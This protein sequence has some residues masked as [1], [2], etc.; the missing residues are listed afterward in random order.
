[1]TPRKPRESRK[2][3]DQSFMEFVHGGDPDPAALAPEEAIPLAHLEQEVIG[4]QQRFALLEQAAAAASPPRLAQLA[5]EINQLAQRLLQ[6]EQLE[7]RLEELGDRLVA[8]EETW[9]AGTHFKQF[10]DQV[11]PLIQVKPMQDDHPQL[12]S[13]W[14]ERLEELKQLLLQ[15]F[16]RQAA[17]RQRVEQQLTQ[18]NQQVEDL[19]LDLNQLRAE[20]QQSLNSLAPAVDAAPPPEDRGR[21]TSPPQA[22][23][24]ALGNHA[25]E[26]PETALAAPLERSSATPGEPQPWLEQLTSLLDDF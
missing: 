15:G 6:L 10:E 7:P 25:T 1:M 23:A 11:T 20:W 2:P 8:L 18:L 26:N 3:L 24:V 16:E 13:D 4:L 19:R 5:S 12:P 21:A 14:P 22:I 17:D 9:P